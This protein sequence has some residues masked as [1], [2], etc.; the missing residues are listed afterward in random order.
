MKAILR[1]KTLHGDPA[2][3]YIYTYIAKEEPCISIMKL[4]LL[5][6]EKNYPE[7]VLVR[8]Y[9]DRYLYREGIHITLCTFF[10]IHDFVR[11]KLIQNI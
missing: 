9:K 6:E 4:V 11:N 3:I 10:S 5:K 1:N 8:K 2:K 7:F